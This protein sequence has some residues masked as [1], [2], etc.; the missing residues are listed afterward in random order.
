MNRLKAIFILILTITVLSCGTINKS[1]NDLD[2]DSKKWKSGD[3][4]TKGKMTDNLLNDSLL[5]GKTKDEI[6]EMLGEPD[7]R[8]ASRLHYTVDPGIEYMNESW[9]YWFS[10]EIDTTSGKVDEVWIAD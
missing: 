1:D 5:I 4:R 7:Q 10:V 9:T 2:F 6:L 3:I 8:T